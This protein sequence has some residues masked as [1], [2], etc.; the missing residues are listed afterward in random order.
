[1]AGNL[2]YAQ[3]LANYGFVSSETVQK[4]SQ[5]LEDA[6]LTNNDKVE[7][8]LLIGVEFASHI[9]NNYWHL[10]PN[11]SEKV[12]T[13]VRDKFKSYFIIGLQ[14]RIEFLNENETESF[15]K[16]ALSIEEAE[17]R[18]NV[19]GINQTFKWFVST[20]S[21]YVIERFKRNYED[22]IIYLEGP[23]GHVAFQPNVY[24]KTL[25]DVELLSRCNDTIL[26]GGSTFG[27]IG[28]LKTR[29]LPY[30]IEG[31]QEK[32]ECRL[33]KL[34]SPAVRPEGYALF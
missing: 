10:K 21:Y 18:N 5:S 8:L 19:L 14:I 1:M 32:T 24:E 13:F 11:I 4:A 27:F 23:I 22:R 28:T 20:D 29:K 2:K 9:L 31:K 17:K 25:M 15:V 6:S 26:T 30:F 33:F 7:Q 34:F 16:C 3:K 12:N